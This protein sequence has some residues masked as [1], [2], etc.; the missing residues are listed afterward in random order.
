MQIVNKPDYSY[1]MPDRFF[2]DLRVFFLSKNLGISVDNSQKDYP[3]PP[4]MNIINKISSYFPVNPK[5]IIFMNQ[6]HS[7]MVI[8]KADKRPS[9]PQAD[10]IITQMKGLA[11]AVKSADCLPI[12]LFDN[13]NKVISA[14]HS[15]WRGT[16]LKI[17]KKALKKFEQE[18]NSNFSDIYVFIGPAINGSC[19][20]IGK[21]VYQH[22]GFLGKKRADYFNR[23]KN[24]K[25]YMDLKGINAYILE[26]EGIPPENIE[27]CDLCTHCESALFH[28]YRRDGVNAG[29]NIS[30]II[31]A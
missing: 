12:F 10:G 5:H 15:G 6:V 7:D 3:S 26:Q 14:I 29:R 23:A 4:D 9:F 18:F 2:S 11:L 1:I 31:L 27:I 8:I 20:E 28:S 17:V 16:A 19:Y 24:N 25:F 21:D 22:F 13:K 30:F